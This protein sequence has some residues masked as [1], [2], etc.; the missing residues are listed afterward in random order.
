[1]VRMWRLWDILRW[2]GLLHLYTMALTEAIR[3]DRWV[4]GQGI[5]LWH[6]ED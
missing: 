1:M 5:W 4:L 6:P 3:E 2:D